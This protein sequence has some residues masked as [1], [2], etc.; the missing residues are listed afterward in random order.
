MLVLGVSSELS[1][2]LISV[3]RI[4]YS[5]VFMYGVVLIF[6]GAWQLKQ[7]DATTVKVSVFGALMLC[8][9]PLIIEFLFKLFGF[10]GALGLI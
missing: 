6:E 1:A 10:E 5:I 4:I 7:G 2:A 8:M 3:I 9:G